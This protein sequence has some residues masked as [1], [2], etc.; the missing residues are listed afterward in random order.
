MRTHVPDVINTRIF[1]HIE[2]IE[3]IEHI[4]IKHKALQLRR[5][6]AFVIAQGFTRNYYTI[7][8]LQPEHL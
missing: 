3:H 8:V 2:H 4:G 6:F 7:P 5:A 1:Y